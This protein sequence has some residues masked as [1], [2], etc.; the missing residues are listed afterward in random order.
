MLWHDYGCRS[1]DVVMVCRA[2]G[3]EP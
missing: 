3:D 1:G 2:G